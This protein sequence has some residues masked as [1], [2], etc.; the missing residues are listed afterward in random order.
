MWIKGIDAT[1]GQPAGAISKEA[2]MPE[3]DLFTRLGVA[4][5]IGLMVG[6]ERGWK[7]RGVEDH[8]RAAGFRTYGLAG[9]LGGVSGVLAPTFG[10]PFVGLVFIAFSAAFGAFHWIEAQ[11]RG[12]ASAT[13]VV[14][15]MLTFLLGALAAVGQVQAAIAAA[16]AMTVLLALREP[17]HRWLAALTWEE[18]R[19]ALILLVMSFLLLPLLPDRA[20]DPWGAVNLHEVWLLAIMI[21][22]ISFAGYVAVRAFGDRLGILLTA[23]AGGLASS[24]AA[25]L[26]F[27]RLA[28]GHPLAANLLAGGVLISGAVMLVRVGVIAGALNPGLIG[29]LWLPLALAALVQA[30]VALSLILAANRQRGDQPTAQLAITNPLAV[31]TSLRLAGFIVV[32][33][34]AVE[35]VQRVWG[36]GGVLAVAALAGVADVD[37]ITISIA[38]A[39]AVA[40]LA[41]PAI[42]LAVAVNTAA[43]AVMAAWLGGAAIGLRVALGS[44]AALVAG[45]V[46]FFAGG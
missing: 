7:A 28:R 22:L 30:G 26:T 34:L 20:V 39:E 36:G 46:A 32:V 24:T 40:A 31:A 13:S 10:G 35:L 9:L 44:L 6:I 5:A 37:A 21:A 42:L 3:I 14:A 38:R 1:P 25:T 33:M 19:A 12:A 4:L 11:I 8:R 29:V 41:A 16:V 18:I 17:L 27:A 45:A 15:G 23:A 43:K 2:V